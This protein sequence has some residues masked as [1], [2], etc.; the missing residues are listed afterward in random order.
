MRMP[1]PLTM[2]AGLALVVA[3]L[4][5]VADDRPRRPDLAASRVKDDFRETV[6][7]FLETY[8]LR[9]HGPEKPK[10]DLDLSAFTTAESAANDLPRWRLVQEQLEAGTMPPPKANRRP[11]DAER[12][13]TIAWITAVRRLEAEKNAGDPGRVP[14][15][16]LSNAEYDH[17]IRDL[18]GFDLRPAREFPVDPA[19]E[20]G[21]DNS[22]ESL[23]MSPALV[24]KYLEAARGSPITSSSSPTAWPSRLI[25][26]WPT[27]IATS[28]AST[29]S[30]TFTSI[31]ARI[32][33]TTSWRPGDSATGRTWA[34]PTRRSTPS[35]TSRGS[36]ASISRPSGPCSTR[37]RKTWARS[38]RSRRCG[39]SCPRPA[40]RARRREGRLRADA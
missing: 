18:T 37:E 11:T 8:C 30:S 26:C 10:G 16:R 14:A 33:P 19:N 6:R 35:R 15:R 4:R 20:A 29:R 23:A 21:F 40:R 17:T 7:P 1:L 34:A 25:R 9:C 31:R 39:E 28:I 32:T 36:A 38:R 24:K 5:L 22:A 3:G 12:Q 2:T 13:A 27:P